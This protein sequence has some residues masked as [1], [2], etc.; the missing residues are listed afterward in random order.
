VKYYRFKTA[1]QPEVVAAYSMRRGEVVP[2]E[3]FTVRILDRLSVGAGA[4]VER[5]ALRR[6]HAMTPLLVAGVMLR[7]HTNARV[8]RQ[9]ERYNREAL[10]RFLHE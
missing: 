5:G 3:Q 9:G 4:Q 10:L 7:G 2:N 8:M 6:R 1:A